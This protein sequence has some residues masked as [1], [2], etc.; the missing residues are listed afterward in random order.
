[1][2]SAQLFLAL[3]HKRD[4]PMAHNEIHKSKPDRRLTTKHAKFGKRQNNFFFFEDC[5]HRTENPH[6]KCIE[7]LEN[8]SC[9]HW[10]LHTFN[11]KISKRKA[12]I[13]DLHVHHRIWVEYNLH[14]FSHLLWPQFPF[15]KYIFSSWLFCYALRI[16]RLY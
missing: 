5:K 13:L 9:T 12:Q 10:M 7:C 16:V 4:T 11:E 2:I 3:T 14:F 1:M 8:R 6:S 15:R